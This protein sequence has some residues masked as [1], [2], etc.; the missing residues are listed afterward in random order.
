M[1]SAVLEHEKKIQQRRGEHGGFVYEFHKT[2]RGNV[3]A[4]IAEVK[5]DE[6]WLISVMPCDEES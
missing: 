5:K 6:C 1:K 4:V 2:I 3:R